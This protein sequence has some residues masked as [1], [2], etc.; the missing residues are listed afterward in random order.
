[1]GSARPWHRRSWGAVGGARSPHME[2]G[3]PVDELPARPDT[4]RSP[5]MSQPLL[6]AMRSHACGGLRAVHAG[7]EVRLAGWVAR[8]RDHGGLVFL[9]LRDASGVVQVVVH[10]EQAPEAAAAAHEVRTED[11]VRTTGMVFLRPAGNE[12]P[13]LPTGE[14]EVIASDLEVLARSDTPPFPLEGRVEVDEVLRLRHRYLDLRR[15]A[16]RRALAARAR[17]NAV[18]RRVLEERGF[19]EVET[20]YL[21]RSTPEGARDFLVPTHL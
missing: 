11:C 20:P 17:T 1:M 6:G 14:V 10:P 2:R 15:P 13:E 16:G 12:N 8:R 4:L 7:E 18:L 5:L 3:R 19:L 9:D 21:T